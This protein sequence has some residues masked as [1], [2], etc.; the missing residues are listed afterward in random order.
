MLDET[1]KFGDDVTTAYAMT[2]ADQRGQVARNY[3]HNERPL[4]TE[5]AGLLRINADALLI[6]SLLDVEYPAICKPSGAPRSTNY[7]ELL[8]L[9]EKDKKNIEKYGG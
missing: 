5:F 6:A 8:E 1:D 9:L 2:T 7:G 4:H 3:L